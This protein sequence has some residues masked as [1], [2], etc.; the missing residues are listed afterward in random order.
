MATS[1]LPS[2]LARARRRF[3]VW[4][5]QRPAGSRIPQALWRL[6]VRLVSRHGVSRTSGVLGVDGDSLKKRAEGVRRMSGVFDADGYSLKER[7]E[8]TAVPETPLGG[9]AFIE[10]PTPAVSSKQCL[11]ELANSAGAKLRLHLLGFDATEIEIIAHRL[12]NAD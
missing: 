8:A 1:Q 3:Q 2:D 6:A 9:P 4:R 12:W 5:A 7:A 11:L 10:L